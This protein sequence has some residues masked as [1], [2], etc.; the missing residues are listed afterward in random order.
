MTHILLVKS[1]VAT[2]LSSC[3]HSAALVGSAP[4]SFSALLT[5]AF[6]L[7]GSFCGKSV[8]RGLRRRTPEADTRKPSHQAP[9]HLT[10]GGGGGGETNKKKTTTTSLVGSCG[11]TVY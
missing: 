5:S 4:L 3:T 9:I 2:R 11:N 1:L 7:P 8:I 10:Q 6:R